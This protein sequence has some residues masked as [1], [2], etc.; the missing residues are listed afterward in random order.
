MNDTP[1]VCENCYSG[2]SCDGCTAPYNEARYGFENKE[3]TFSQALERLKAGHS[4]ARAAWGTDEGC[5]A[6][7]KSESPQ[8]KDK[9]VR[10][11]PIGRG[12]KMWAIQTEDILANDWY[13]VDE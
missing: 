10:R 12:G 8:Y 9:I 13:Q 7:L 1:Q 4:I 2:E 3:L 6:L 11:V 5:Y